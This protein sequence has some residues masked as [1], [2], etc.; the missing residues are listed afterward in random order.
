MNASR[1]EG[2][3]LWV[4]GVNVVLEHVGARG[5]E[6]Q[7]VNTTRTERGKTIHLGLTWDHHALAQPWDGVVVIEACRRTKHDGVLAI[8]WDAI[9][10]EPADLDSRMG[11]ASIQGL[12]VGAGQILLEGMGLAKRTALK[13]VL[14]E[15]T[16]YSA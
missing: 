12:R 6:I 4:R 16:A 7:C 13:L 11:R 9:R 2:R 10:A 5:V 3:S 14:D 15:G 8:V 1:D